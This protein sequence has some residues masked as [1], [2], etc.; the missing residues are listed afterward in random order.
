VLALTVV[1]AVACFPLMCLA[2]GLPGGLPGLR[3]PIASGA[4]GPVSGTGS[5]LLL[6]RGLRRSLERRTAHLAATLCSGTA[7]VRACSGPGS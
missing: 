7:T 6:R 4:G 2:F 3:L 5:G 1:L